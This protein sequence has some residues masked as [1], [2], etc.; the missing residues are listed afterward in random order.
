MAVTSKAQ[1]GVTLM[2]METPVKK[3]SPPKKK[4]AVSPSEERKR[5]PVKM[6]MMM[7]DDEGSGSGTDGG[8]DIFKIGGWGD[9]PAKKGKML[10][11]PPVK[12]SPA[13]E[14]D[15]E[16]GDIYAALGWDD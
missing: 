11:A 6:S 7:S 14:W 9:T 15:N 4:R 2:M 1:G 16:D 8:G 3:P 12:K 13:K 10:Q 5:I